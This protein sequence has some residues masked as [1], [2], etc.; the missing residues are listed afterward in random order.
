MKTRYVLLFTIALCAPSQ[1]GSQTS[2]ESPAAVADSFLSRFARK[3]FL[4]ATKLVDSASME[5][6]RVASVRSARSSDSLQG[7]EP[8]R[9]SEVP[10]AVAEYLEAQARRARDAYGSHLEREFGV[11][12][13]AELERMGASGVFARWLEGQHPETEFR[14]AVALS[15]ESRARALPSI[16]MQA[17]DPIVLGTVAA[18]DSLA[19]AVFYG[20]P[21]TSSGLPSVLPVRL[22]SIGWRIRADEAEMAIINGVCSIGFAVLEADGV[23]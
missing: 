5:D 6:F 15:T 1:A 8:Q 10:P 19:Y 3:D 18:S 13:V 22:T 2:G 16:V 14:R 9:R 11:S 7:A 21:G 23:P 12:T 17:P 20:G 4:G